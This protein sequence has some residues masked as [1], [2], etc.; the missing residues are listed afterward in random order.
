MTAWGAM[1]ERIES[2]DAGEVAA[3]ARRLDEAERRAVAKEL[4]GYL[5]E[6][7]ARSEWG[8][9]DAEAVR[10][11]L[12][13]GAGTLGGPAAV[14]TWLS[15]RDLRTWSP[16]SFAGRVVEAALDRP[17]EWRA[18][19]ARRLA[20]RLR[21]DTSR[22]AGDLW[23]FTAA[24][25]RS[26]GLEPPATDG[27]VAG[28]VRRRPSDPRVLR[29]DPWA[30]V[31]L[32]RVFEVDGI[33]A[34][35]GEEWPERIAALAEEGRFDRKPLLDGCVSR[36]LRGGEARDLRWFVALH[37]ALAPTPDESFARLRDHVRL[38][39][40]SPAAVA[41]MALR[42][43]RRA[44][45]DGRLG[46][47]E[48]AEAADALLFR[49]EKKL[50]RAALIW[51][52]RTAR[53]RDRVDATLAA[54][55][56]VFPSEAL[57]LRERAV[58]VAVRHAAHVT[59]EQTNAAVREAAAVLPADLREA[60]AAAFGEVDAP[61]AGPPVLAG[62]PPFTPRTLPPPIA[63]AAELAEEF[64]ARMRTESE[65]TG[66]ER[67][68][69]GVVE[70]AYRDADAT[71]EAL[72]RVLPD[73][74]SW[75]MSDHALDSYDPGVWATMCVR[76]LFDPKAKRGLVDALGSFRHGRSWTRGD[77]DVPVLDRF[78]RWRLR[79][80][81]SAV[82]RA[83][84]LLSTPTEGSGHIDPGVLVSR[85]ERLE[86]AGAE[87]G[88][89][90]LAQALLRLPRDAAGLDGDA[91]SRAARLTSKA[92]RAVAAWLASGGLA[93]P[94]VECAMVSLPQRGPWHGSGRPEYVAGTVATVLAAGDLPSGIAPLLAVPEGGEWRSLPWPYY[95][96]PMAWWPSMLPSHR[97][98]AAAH[99]LP[100]S[101]NWD[102]ARVGQG[103]LLAGLA[104]ADGPAGTA[105]AHVLAYG[106]AASHA[107]ERAAA[108]DAF[109]AFAGRGALPAAGLGTALGAL[110]ARDAV[111]LNRA[112]R[113]LDGVAD[114]GAYADVLTVIL[115]ALPVLLP[116]PGE[117][118]R[119]GLHDLIAL[120][121]R[122]AEATGARAD[123]PG[124]AAVAARGGTSRL[125]REAAR[126]HRTLT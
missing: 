92:G 44:D 30:D 89:A 61:E 64:V 21:I 29:D 66:I 119:S 34:L 3:F 17:A 73:A 4:P 91:V 97:E 6:R 107:D 109:A 35:L 77:R 60:I 49:P 20:E 7:V 43:V 32:P 51:L 1:R 41:E 36:F 88:R 23:E 26:T 76:T 33:G 94:S 116:A 12:V 59:G 42:E 55:T 99:V 83:P 111:T 95:Y 72:L 117:R 125:V 102:D 62:P 122:A 106:L 121:T 100:Y 112:A 22:R 37:D 13:A 11:L 31:L 47:E 53:K 19:V 58:R 46:A 86:A 123:V 115:A 84:V 126:L 16:E 87:P 75:E 103:A 85:L 114:T 105:T 25:A 8:W 38:L 108:V 67:L 81:S 27:F 14:A 80:A 71:R 74:A 10:P 79:E 98:V 93:D 120:G 28:W 96:G 39:P 45:D 48:F 57:D 5:R 104:E 70:L 124:L 101:R 52:D 69:A 56:A 18:E 65:W 15:R 113:A 90:D 68:V 110:V 82:G 118:P 24:F 9:L 2:G 54:L 78:L 40:A 63:S 50:V